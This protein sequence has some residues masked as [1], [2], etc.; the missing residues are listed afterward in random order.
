MFLQ[1]D[2]QGGLSTMISGIVCTI[3]WRG[4]SENR[5]ELV[6]DIEVNPYDYSFRAD[7]D[8]LMEKANYVH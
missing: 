2:C 4:N 8:E 7:K 3:Q 6:P 1:F 5:A